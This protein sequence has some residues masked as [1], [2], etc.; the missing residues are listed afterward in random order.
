MGAILEPFRNIVAPGPF[1]I[2]TGQLSVDW[3][4]SLANSLIGCWLPGSAGFD[5]LGLVPLRLAVPST[6]DGFAPTVH[7]VGLK[8]TSNSGGAGAVAPSRF[9]AWT[10]F[11][12]FWYG[13]RIGAPSSPAPFLI[14][15]SYDNA[16]GTP[17]VVAG[18]AYDGTSITAQW[19][20]G[21]TF[22]FSQPAFSAGNQILYSAAIVFRVN[23]TN[24]IF[25]NGA[26]IGTVAFGASGPTSSATSTFAIN[27]YP[28]TSRNI[29][30]II[31]AGYVWDRALS[32]D[33]VA[34][35]HRDPY[36]FLI[37]AEY[38]MPVLSTG[39]A[40]FISG[41]SRQ[42]NLPVIGGGTF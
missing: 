28:G 11:T 17:F 12:L 31:N 26:S 18:V 14:G 5:N 7:G 42:S 33:E 22:S 9:K 24:A 39:V 27:G 40:A 32:N 8:N 15:V 38:E 1:Q 21:G 19:N 25:G 13:M 23:G 37:S 35:L 3:N 41:W 10:G 36:G 4:H 34:R 20:T 16:G 2:P 6:F 30:S 29:N